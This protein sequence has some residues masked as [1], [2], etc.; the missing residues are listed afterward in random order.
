MPYYH[1]DFLYPFGFLSE[2]MSWLWNKKMQTYRF[3]LLLAPAGMFF[4][5]KSGTWFYS[6][7][8]AAQSLL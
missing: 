4:Q 6:E 7:K 1:D 2:I 8:W 3:L 5:K